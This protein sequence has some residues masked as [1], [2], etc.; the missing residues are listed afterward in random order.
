[1]MFMNA[2]ERYG[3]FEEERPFI[4][5]SI[6]LLKNNRIGFLTPDII[7]ATFIETDFSANGI[8]KH[9]MATTLN[10]KHGA[11]VVITP[12][13][14]STYKNLVD[15]LDELRIV[16]HMRYVLNTSLSDKELELSSGQY[17]H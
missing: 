2:P 5:A 15:I 7:D 17:E 13:N 9:L 6:L 10:H 8:R 12:T 3:C 1:M 11:F 4:D 14:W 16:G